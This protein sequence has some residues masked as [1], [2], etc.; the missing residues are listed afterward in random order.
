MKILF[1]ILL[2]THFPNSFQRQLIAGIFLPRLK[3][4]SFLKPLITALLLF[5]L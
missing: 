1:F 3:L 4:S 5:P 2:L